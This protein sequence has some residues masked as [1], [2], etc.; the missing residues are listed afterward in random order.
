MELICL[1]MCMPNCQW[2]HFHEVIS[3]EIVSNVKPISR[4]LQKNVIRSVVIKMAKLTT[5]LN[6]KNSGTEE[7][8]L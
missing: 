6:R 2:T 5:T 3:G 8:G 7:N 1:A 4:T